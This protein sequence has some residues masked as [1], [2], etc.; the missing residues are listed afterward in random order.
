MHVDHLHL[1]QVQHHLPQVQLHHHLQPLLLH[2]LDL[3]ELQIGK[4]TTGVMMK[5]IIVDV[6]GMV[7]I[8]VEMM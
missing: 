4:V 7:E 5:T 8:V 2:V 6:N 1:P 3:V